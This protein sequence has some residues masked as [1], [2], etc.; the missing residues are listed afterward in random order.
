V[1]LF[2]ETHWVAVVCALVSQP[3]TAEAVSGQI[4]LI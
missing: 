3:C 2:N 1:S 4:E